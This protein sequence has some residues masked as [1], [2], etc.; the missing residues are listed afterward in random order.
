[1]RGNQLLCGATNHLLL[2]RHAA[3]SSVSCPITYLCEVKSVTKYLVR[4]DHL[5]LCGAIA[6]SVRGNQSLTVQARRLFFGELSGQQV[7]EVLQISVRTLIYAQA[8]KGVII[9]AQRVR[10][11]VPVVVY[12]SAERTPD[13]RK[14]R[15]FLDEVRPPESV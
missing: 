3:C 10:S 14:Q 1:M 13:E 12:S 6:Y 7:L 9:W 5:L 8:D 15:G 4:G 2:C 11:S